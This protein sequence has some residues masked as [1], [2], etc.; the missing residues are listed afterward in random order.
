M[1]KAEQ[2]SIL[3]EWA[4]LS[5]APVQEFTVQVRTPKAEWVSRFQS[6]ELQKGNTLYTRKDSQFLND[7]PFMFL[8]FC[9]SV[10]FSPQV[11]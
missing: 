11:D 1:Q 8:D 6:E 5:R 4:Q 3:V 2:A 7:P 10:S 9:R